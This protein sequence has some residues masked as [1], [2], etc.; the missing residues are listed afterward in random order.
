[1]VDS[2]VIGER[3]A[4]IIVGVFL[5]FV[6]I[7][8]LA[9]GVTYWDSGEFLAAIRT[10]GIPHPPGTPLFILTANAWA[11]LL[12]PILGFAYSIN[13]LSAISTATACALFA[14]LLTRWTRDPGAAAAGGISAGLM[15]SVWLNANET[16]VY[17]P[18]LLL[19]IVLLVVAQKAAETKEKKWLIL[20][21][22]LI[23]LGWSLQLSA[24]LSAPAA[25]L[26]ALRVL[27]GERLVSRPQLPRDATRL[28]FAA[29]AAALL[30]ASVTLSMIVRAQ[31]DPPVNQGNPATWSALADVITRRQYMPVGMFPRQAPWYIQLGNLFEYSD[32]Q[33]ALGLSPGA[34]PSLARTPFTIA[35]AI[36]GV[37]GSLWHRRVNRQSWRVMMVLFATATLGVVI[38]LNMKASPSYGHGFLPPNAPHEARERDYFFALAFACWGMWAGAGAV[39]AFRGGSAR[40]RLAGLAVAVLPLFLNFK[41]VD[42]ARGPESRA[43][44]D[45]AQRILRGAPANGVVFANG[46]NDTYPVWYAQ[47]VEGIRQDVITVT[48]PLLGAGWYRDELARRHRLLSSEFVGKWRGFEPTMKAICIAARRSGRPVVAEQVRDRPTI[49]RECRQDYEEPVEF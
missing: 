46:D 28:A 41:A 34:P 37:A 8:T 38:Y 2:D 9:P 16:E 18:S 6:Y 3:R 24:L 4:P 12:G 29:I 23:G 10:L 15:S 27:E 5:L 30:G 36:L 21:A 17:S 31:H 25:L 32:W 19:C 11:K 33:V 43:A 45:S 39:R 47:Q 42:R 22:Y 1:M 20:F 49:P 26:L 48:I 35:F 7:I 14:W 40:V 44:L 13:L